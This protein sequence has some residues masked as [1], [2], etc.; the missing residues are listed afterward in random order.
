MKQLSLVWLAVAAVTGSPPA[1]DAFQLADTNNDGQL[2]KAEFAAF[3]A[4]ATA[5][6]TDDDDHNDNGAVPAA[7]D[8]CSWNSSA[9]SGTAASNVT[10]ESFSADRQNGAVESGVAALSVSLTVNAS[11]GAARPHSI[12]TVTTVYRADEPAEDARVDSARVDA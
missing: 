11:A 9:V 1:G 7:P 2:S 10:C 4:A 5:T 8:S 3:L 6:A 12:D